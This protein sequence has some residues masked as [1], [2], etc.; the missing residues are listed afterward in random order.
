[1][2]IVYKVR[3]QSTKKFKIGSLVGVG[4]FVLAMVMTPTPTEEPTSAVPVAQETTAPVENKA[5]EDDAVKIKAEEKA[6]LKAEEETK[7]KQE[8]E[9]KVAE[10][11]K[12]AEEAKITGTEN[13]YIAFMSKNTDGISKSLS[14]IGTQL[15][16]PQL[17]NQDWVIKTATAVVMLGQYAD[18]AKDYQTVPDKFKEVHNTYLKAMEEYKY[19]STNLPKAIDKHDVNEMNVIAEKMFKGN[20]YVNQA[21]DQILKLK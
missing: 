16:N 19:V 7:A 18:E 10:E 13:D 15:S 4:M 21:T 6:K 20:D 5:K 17:N 12:K 14:S 11:K 8:A 3:K 1:M 9:L 2:W